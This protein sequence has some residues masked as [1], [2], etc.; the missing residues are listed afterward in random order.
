ML[1]R[2]ASTGCIATFGKSILGSNAAN[3]IHPAIP[4]DAVLS[5]EGRAVNLKPRAVTGKTGEVFD[6]PAV[7][8]PQQM[9]GTEFE[10]IGF[11]YG[12]SRA[13]R[14][15]R[16]GRRGRL[17]RQLSL[18]DIEFELEETIREAMERREAE[19]AAAD[20]SSKLLLAPH[21]PHRRLRAV[22][23]SP[24]ADV[25]PLESKGDGAAEGAAAAETPEPQ[26]AQ[27]FKD[28]NGRTLAAAE[29]SNSSATPSLFRSHSPSILQSYEKY[30][31]EEQHQK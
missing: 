31:V 13:G 21:A 17:E 30:K 10:E 5:K 24:F 9:A 6:H 2:V 16:S 25:F 15:G 18:I 22:A 29:T 26:G 23:S 3:G 19:S 8:I 28:F 1:P 27:M 20:A 11:G 14:S 4:A 12:Y 7:V